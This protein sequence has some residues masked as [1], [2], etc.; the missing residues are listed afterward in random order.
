M[1]EHKIEL[2][3]IETD[4]S[5]GTDYD[6]SAG[7]NASGSGSKQQGGQSKSWPQT[8]ITTSDPHMCSQLEAS[9]RSEDLFQ[10]QSR[11]KRGSTV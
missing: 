1:R 10:Q 5:T 4:Y 11:F 7:G 6:N 9:V 3:E 2:R 8:Q